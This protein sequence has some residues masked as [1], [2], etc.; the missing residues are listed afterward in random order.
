MMVGGWFGCFITREGLE[1]LRRYE[2]KGAGSTPI[3]RLLNPWWEYVASKLP[4]WLSPNVL[5]L[6]G[7]LCTV[8]CMSLVAVWMPHLEEPAPRWIY[9]LI[10]VLLFF[11][12]TLD[13]IDG[14][15]ARRTNSSSP[16][17]QLF[18]HGCDS[19]STV[20]AVFINA[21]MARMGVC[22][23]SYL[24]L[25]I[26]QMQMFIYSW[27]EIHFHVYRCHTGVTG[28]TEGQLV[29]M[30]V[31]L[32]GAIFGSDIF[33]LTFGQC[34]E[35]AFGKATA[36]V[37]SVLLDTP[38]QYIISTPFYLLLIY[39]LLS[40][41][42][43]GC[44]LVHNKKQ[45]IPQLV[46]CFSHVLFQFAFFCSGLMQTHPAVCYCLIVINSSI[47]VLRMNISATCRLRFYPIQWP[48]VPFY[49]TSV[50][51]Y[52]ACPNV[53]SPLAALLSSPLSETQR[54]Q[55]AQVIPWVL[56]A[57]SLWSFSYLF[58][59]LLSTITAICSHLDITCFYIRRKT[60]PAACDVGSSQAVL[61]ESQIQTRR[62]AAA[63]AAESKKA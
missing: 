5:T 23:F 4:L 46:G 63:Q 28:V 62:R 19:F 54:D 51:F 34:L 1:E 38:M 25:A 40:D 50:Y 53:S 20:F 17:G 36:F 59:F 13:A 7:F 27:W 52:L 26:L 24:L 3:D 56:L 29:T 32:L 30:G 12:Q 22:L 16:L 44:R 47:V 11:Y 14:K 18:D 10:C 9:L 58:D 49:L 8:M 57:L 42:F 45:A 37:P 41:V 39:M 48:A 61:R 43:N 31:S 6:L 33:L 15:Q 21:A 2:Y 55:Q 35:T 60:H